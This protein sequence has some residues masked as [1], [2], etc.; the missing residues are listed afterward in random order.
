MLFVPPL[1]HLLRAKDL[2]DGHYFKPLGVDDLARAA[3][4]LARAL[5]PRVPPRLR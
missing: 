3:R 2:A 5:Q 1:R 4:P